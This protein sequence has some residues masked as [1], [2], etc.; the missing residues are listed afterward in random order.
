MA[1]E[2]YGNGARAHEGG[3]RH[4]HTARRTGLVADSRALSGTTTIMGGRALTQYA[5]APLA[6]SNA[7]GGG[8]RGLLR[9]PFGTRGGSR[10]GNGSGAPSPRLVRVA[11]A[12]AL[13]IGALAVVASSAGAADPAPQLNSVSGVLGGSAHIT[14][15]IRNN[16]GSGVY[17]EVEY[18]TDDVNW[19]GTG[20]EYIP[21]GNFENPYPVAKDLQGLQGSTKYHVRLM[22][23]L[24]A[25]VYSNELEFETLPVDPPKVL[26]IEDASS[27]LSTIADVAGEV[28]R[29]TPGNPDPGFDAECAFEYI[30]DGQLAENEGN[31]EPPFTGAGQTP[32]NPNPVTTSD[33][34]A[35]TAEL[36]GLSP[37]T[38]YHLRLR[39]TNA[40]G[41]DSKVAAHTFTTGPVSPPTVTLDPIS[42]I[43]D[44]SAHATGVISPAAPYDDP[45]F[46]VSYQFHCTPS[47]S[48]P[49]ELTGQ[50]PADNDDHQ[51]EGDLMGPAGLGLE[52]NTEYTVVLTASNAGGS[53]DSAPQTFRTEAVAPHAETKPAFA[54]QGGTEAVVGGEINAKNSP[55]TYWVEY[56][57]TAS[58]GSSIP[59]SKDAS[60]GAGGKARYFTQKLTGLQP[61]TEYHFRLVAKNAIGTARG[62]DYTFETAP[63][64]PVSESCPNEILRRENN[65]SK[66]PD[67]R[68][69]EKVSPDD[70]NGYDAIKNVDTEQYA[71]AVYVAED[72]SSAIYESY[73]AFA[74]SKAG[75]F[76]TPYLSRR[77]S[78]GWST[79]ALAPPI[80]PTPGVRVE[81]YS[82]YSPDLKYSYFRSTP[83]VNIAPGN[84][85]TKENFF[86]ENNLTDRF[87][88]LSLEHSLGQAGSD[89]E[90]PPY[91]FQFARALVPGAVEGF[92]PTNTYEWNDGEITLASADLPEGGSLQGWGEADGTRRIVMQAT[93]SSVAPDLYL[94]TV[95]PN[96]DVTMTDITESRRATPDPQESPFKYW[97]MSADGSK[98]FFTTGRSLTEDTPL[99]I[100]YNKLY[101]YNANTDELTNI[102]PPS[103]AG[104]QLMGGVAAI[105][106]D[107]SYVYFFSSAQV[108]PGD[109]VEGESA[110]YVWHNGAVK[111]IGV[112]GAPDKT[113]PETRFGET[114]FRLS[115]DGRQLSFATDTRMTNYDNTDLTATTESGDPRPDTEVYTY[116][117]DTE[118][119]TCV[120]CNPTGKRP[121][122]PSGVPKPPGTGPT[123]PQQ[124]G[125]SDSGRIFFNSEDALVPQD[126]N[127][128]RDVYEW[129]DGEVHLLTPGVGGVSTYGGAST[130]GHDV[131]IATREKLIPSDRDEITDVYDV[132]V[133]GGF[134][135][136]TAS[137]LCESNEGCHG[138]ASSAPNTPNAASAGFS[139]DLK[140]L[141]PRAER[142]QKALRACKH[143]PKKKRAKCR[144]TAKKRYG[145][146]APAA[147]GRAH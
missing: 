13:A 38:T 28:E 95:K 40:G 121:E 48:E 60:A 118:R 5:K 125:V 45:G 105:S 30:S 102:S 83:P 115:P 73:G 142:L 96:G 69:Y 4:L 54:I 66:L 111:M 9:R 32:C 46:E 12:L 52:P 133:D 47:C 2:E 80:L 113:E 85:P 134:P 63:A 31:G 147:N 140:P 93:G 64:G 91:V 23:S 137:S 56:G 117:F 74:D 75:A 94:R 25:P 50:V 27:V 92:G 101:E 17:Y 68:A 144:A 143:K 138:P 34:P 15:E 104:P 87:Y 51:V 36:T 123:K 114:R 14:G 136:P 120:S 129:E 19:F 106:R 29:P 61:S 78:E 1:G 59:S 108:R 103:I 126:V 65:S 119:L 112:G 109:N 132:R 42:G 79:H 26:S 39:A 16:P 18:S 89:P 97:G 71:G 99:D 58:Y 67:C 116:D 98:I 35:V 81:F 135:Q 11:I 72:G 21:N 82:E 141:S 10:D 76:L 84:N 7:T 57:P 124:M 139:S 3:G 145:K 41:S 24:F 127:G 86:L 43:T 70:K 22:S 44:T 107:G 146:K 128:K 100:G 110:L 55:T 131:Y 90:T 33:S 20:G 6:E 77:G 130:D 88:T 8:S 37:E 53:V 122:G 49:F 62:N